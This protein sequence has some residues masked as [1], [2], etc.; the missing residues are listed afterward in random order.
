MMGL[1][2][3]SSSC[4][5]NPYPEKAGEIVTVK[6]EP[7]PI[8][9][10]PFGLEVDDSLVFDVGVLGTYG[11][12][13]WAPGVSQVTVTGL[14]DGAY[15]SAEESKILWAPTAEAAIDP[16]A[17]NSG[18]RS[19]KVLVEV[20]GTETPD[21]FL[22]KEVTIVARQA[23]H[24]SQVAVDL[25]GASHWVVK[26]LGQE[27]LSFE[28]EQDADGTSP[29]ISIWSD[30]LPVSVDLVVNFS[31]G[32]GT[33][34]YVAYRK[35]GAVSYSRLVPVVLTLTRKSGQVSQVS[36]VMQVTE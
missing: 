9:V 1:G 14:P 26:A 18:S 5:N 19:Y 4:S 11:I 30:G 20:S 22:A 13:A 7:E 35:E 12:K 21:S 2:L 23:T 3:G 10:A 31:G 25:Q 27:S 24:F 16:D 34:T 32:K 36:F 33:L 8:K 15:F 17:P 29:E 28:Y 6:P